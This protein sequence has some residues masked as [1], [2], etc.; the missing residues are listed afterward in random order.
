[1]MMAAAVL[2]VGCVTAP[3]GFTPIYRNVSYKVANET[4]EGFDLEIAFAEFAHVST[5]EGTPQI[6]RARKH[7]ENA[8]TYLAAN[9]GKSIQSIAFEKVKPRKVD[10][11]K[12]NDIN[13]M[14]LGERVLY[15][16]GP[17]PDLAELLPVIKAKPKSS[18]PTAARNPKQP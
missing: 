5:S 16:A 4:P 14:H 7:F 12:W 6:Q 18:K 1:M 15:G 8:A 10:H 3:K 13:I 2:A 11:D 17:A 9:R